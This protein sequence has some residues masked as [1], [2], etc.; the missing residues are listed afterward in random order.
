MRPIRFV[1]AY[2]WKVKESVGADLRAAR[3]RDQTKTRCGA[4]AGGRGRPPLPRFRRRTDRRAAVRRR[5]QGRAS[6]KR[7]R[8][9]GEGRHRPPLGG[10]V[11]RQ[12]PL[13]NRVQ[14]RGWP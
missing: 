4:V 1:A 14:E 6:Q 11:G 3:N 10:E 7:K 5:V 8:H 12:V 2:E 9:V 13:R